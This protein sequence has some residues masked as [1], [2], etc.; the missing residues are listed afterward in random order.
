MILSENRFPLFGIMRLPATGERALELLGLE[1]LLQR[2]P[3]AI[4]L[5]QAVLAIAGD[6]DERQAALDQNIRHRKNLLAVEID[7]ENGD[8]EIA[9]GGEVAGLGDGADRCADGKAEIGQHVLQQHA[10]QI[11]ILD[12]ENARFRC[13][14]IGH[15]L[16]P[17]T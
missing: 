5:G 10:D 8:V 6:E 4:G 2:R 7:V 15:C 13:R 1:R 14:G 17:R 11:F 9:L 12:H 3:A 16:S